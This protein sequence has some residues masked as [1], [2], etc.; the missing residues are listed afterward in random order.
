MSDKTMSGVLSGVS[1]E[2]CLVSDQTMSGVM[3]G[4]R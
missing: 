4:V 2:C 3:S 1:K